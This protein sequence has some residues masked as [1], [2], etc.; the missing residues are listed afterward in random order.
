MT[1]PDFNK[2]TDARKRIW[3]ITYSPRPGRSRIIEGVDLEEA[4]SKLWDALKEARE[5]SSKLR[6]DMWAQIFNKALDC[7][8]ATR[9]EFSYHHDLIP[10]SYYSLKAR[11]L[12][13]AAEQAWVFGGMGSWNDIGFNNPLTTRKYNKIS[14]RLYSSTLTAFVAATNQPS[15]SS[16]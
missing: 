3:D 12:L 2:K 4:R 13:A 10:E 9:P 1:I 16:N 11:Q 6:S 15:L 5:F 14:K 7:Y 8:S